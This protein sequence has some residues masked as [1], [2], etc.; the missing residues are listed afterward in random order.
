MAK[1]T[2]QQAD[3]SVLELIYENK[4]NNA[5]VSINAVVKDAIGNKYNFPVTGIDVNTLPADAITIVRSELT[6]NIDH[7]DN[8]VQNL[9]FQNLNLS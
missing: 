3:D 1:F 8:T 2:T 6:V 7:V 5:V 4:V 9:L